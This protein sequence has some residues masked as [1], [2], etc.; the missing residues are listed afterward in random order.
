MNDWRD[1]VSKI[2]GTGF[3]LA[4]V[5]A[6]AIVMVQ[7]L[8]EQPG[9]IALEASTDV[10]TVEIVREIESV[11]ATEALPSV[12]VRDVETVPDTEAL[13]PEL[14]DMTDIKNR[15]QKGQ[16]VKVYDIPL[17]EDLQLH[18]TNLCEEYHIEPT[19]IYAMIA[20]ESG[21]NANAMGDNGK[22][23]G[24]MQIQLRYVRARMDKLGCTDLLDPYQN[25]AVG[26]D[27]ISEYI[28]KGYGL[29]WALMAYNGGEAYAYRLRSEGY[30]SN[31]AKTV[32]ANSEEMKEEG[33]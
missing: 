2:F 17:D 25:V 13:A 15:P 7:G 11:H 10:A 5:T 33:E 24:L 31:Y 14:L 20:R 28:A 30:V 9:G 1:I 21:Y 22:S 12:P 16:A 4:S 3:V 27:L 23:Y 29:E 26:I 6:I 8:Q 18:I 19:L 32:I